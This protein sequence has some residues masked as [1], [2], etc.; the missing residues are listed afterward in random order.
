MSCLRTSLPRIHAS[1]IGLATPR[2]ARVPSWQLLVFPEPLPIIQGSYE[3]RSIIAP[4][5]VRKI[6]SVV[7]RLRPRLDGIALGA[8]HP[9]R[10]RPFWPTEIMDECFE[11]F[12]IARGS[13]K[14]KRGSYFHTKILGRC[15]PRVYDLHIDRA[16]V[17]LVDAHASTSESTSEHN[18]ITGRNAGLTEELHVGKEFLLGLGQDIAG[19]EH[20]IDL[21]QQCR[22]L[23]DRD[24]IASVRAVVENFL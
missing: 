4:V 23:L 11:C 16:P 21:F 5:R 19:V 8:D 3:K 9:A 17:L 15:E 1:P 24:P 10:D 7:T 22:R 18:R 14:R 2:T 20:G 6:R 12:L 13:D